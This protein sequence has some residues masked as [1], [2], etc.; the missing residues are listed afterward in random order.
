M[1]SNDRI[2]LVVHGHFYQPPRENPWTDEVP[3]EPSAAPAH[4]WNE[5]INDECYRANA[6]A[7]IFGPDD[8]IREM[9][10]NYAYLSFNFGPTLARWIERHDPRTHARLADGDRAQ[11]ARHGAGGAMAQV[12]GHPIAP[13]LSPNDRRTQILWGLSDFERRFGRVSEGIWLPETAVDAPTLEAL[14]DAGVTFTILAPEQIAAV[15]PPGGAWAQVNR[16]TIDTG[17]AY[18]WTH[19]DGSGRSI[20]LCVFDG[21]FSREIAFGTASRDAGSFVHQVEAAA[22][23]SKADGARLVLVASDGEL[24]GH[25]KK[26][27]DLTLAYALSREAPARGVE[28][29]NLAD[30][31]AKEPPTWEAELAKGPHGEGTAWSCAHGVGRWRRHC[32]CAMRPEH[33]GWRQDWRAPLR[34]GLDLLRDRAATFYEDAAADLFLDPWGVRDAY[35]EVIDASPDVRRAFLRAQGREELAG[36]DDEA[37]RRALLLLEMQRSLLLMYSSCGWFFDDVAGI[38]S[39]LVLR[40]AARA[41]DLWSA[42]GGAPPVD[43]LLDVLA[44]GR[45]N[46]STLGSGADVYRRAA[47]H[48]ITPRHAAAQAAVEGLLRGFEG[49]AHIEL[50]GYRVALA[51]A[52]TAA[53]SGHVLRAEAEVEH[54]RTGFVEPLAVTA[55]TDDRGALELDVDGSPTSLA[56]L[57]EDARDP[58]LFALLSNVEEGHEAPVEKARTALRIARGSLSTEAGRLLAR[59]LR[60]LLD[61]THARDADEE[62]FAVVDALVTR[63]TEAGAQEAET[64][65]QEWLWERV[66]DH[67]PAPRGHLRALAERLRFSLDRPRPSEGAADREV[68]P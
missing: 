64:M 46:V 55:A 15:R 31:L 28:V 3:R 58:L 53:R 57:P 30:F 43:D 20:A 16:E 67:A 22:S 38:E 47:G 48:R 29:T 34:D 40:Q 27:A 66:G 1:R 52:R 36:G 18:K 35:G 19:G 8:R 6:F 62:I 61:A 44:R 51:G 12:W 23:R 10:N 17:R 14:I 49:R 2:A 56:E 59:L 54:R 13:L 60:A 68:S 21:P 24:Y 9:V 25:H 7:R 63:A 42:L 50:P 5:R 45:S 65:T 32:G 11:I 39:A 33:D 26:F 4:D 41:V 37:M